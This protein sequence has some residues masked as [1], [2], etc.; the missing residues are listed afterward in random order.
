MKS[1]EEERLRALLTKAYLSKE[2]GTIDEFWVQRVMDDIQRLGP[3]DSRQS[4]LMQ[5]E[6]LVWRFAPVACV[7]I[8]A[9]ALYIM[10]VD[11][12][13]EYEIAQILINDPVGFVLIEPAII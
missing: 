3:F 1:T 5:F 13:P 4:F 9:L 11:F 12:V 8:I 6:K 2:G 10:R 7:L